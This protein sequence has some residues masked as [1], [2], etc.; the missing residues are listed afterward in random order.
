VRALLSA[1][2]P[3]VS[4]LPA[5]D[6]R[7][8]ELEL[9]FPAARGT[10]LGAVLALAGSFGVL[11]LGMSQTFGRGADPGLDWAVDAL[12][13]ALFFVVESLARLWVALQLGE[14]MGSLPVWLPVSLVRGLRAAG[15]RRAAP[16][17]A[18]AGD[19]KRRRS[20]EMWV[21]SLG[22]LFGLLD[23]A[24]Q[25]R[26]AAAVPSFDPRRATRASILGTAALALVGAFSAGLYLA[27]DPRPVDAVVLAAC[28]ALGLDA[29]S[30]HLALRRGRIQ[31][32]VAGVLLLPLARR[33]VA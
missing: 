2:A 15:S 19:E 27:S 7:R 5:A 31:G 22:P 21:E 33:L 18:G 8:L 14:P 9:G 4:L 28:G 32:S 16:S 1:L 6:Q 23:G 17:R 11:L 24:T 3:L 26:L 29:W 25:E 12:P 13:F 10:L 30:R 20:R